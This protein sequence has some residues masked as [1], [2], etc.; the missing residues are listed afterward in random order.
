MTKKILLLSIVTFGLG[1][2]LGCGFVSPLTDSGLTGLDEVPTRTPQPTFTLGPTEALITVS[3][4]IATPIPSSPMP[5]EPSPTPIP[6]DR[7]VPP[8]AEV[9]VDRLNVRNGPGTNY[10]RIGSVSLGHKA[11]I[12]GRNAD[13]SW[14]VIKYNDGQGWIS[15]QYVN[16]TGDVNNLAVI[17][18]SAAPAPVQVAASRPTNT[19][20]PPPPAQEEPP[21]PQYKYSIHNAFGEKNEGITQIRGYIGEASNP[22][23]GVNGVRVRVRSGSFCTVSYPSGTPGVYP[24]GNYDVLLDN[25]AKPGNWQVAIVDK[26]TNPEDTRCDPAANVLSEEITVPTNTVEGVVYVEW[27]RNF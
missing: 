21:Q 24:P 25:K 11:E 2:G 26:P 8:Q 12:V 27:R 16:I 7:P 17:E 9:T 14:I 15:A 20:L 23:S 3:V 6:T 5:A 22:K 1:F 18:A 19:P 13:S 4:A 10:A